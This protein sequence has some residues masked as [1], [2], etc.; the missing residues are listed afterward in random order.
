MVEPGLLL[1]GSPP[2]ARDYP[3]FRRRWTIGP[4]SNGARDALH[5]TAASPTGGERIDIEVSVE[6]APAVLWDAL[7]YYILVA[8][9]AVA[10]VPWA[11]LATGPSSP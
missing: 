6:T 10:L 3:K 11:E 8:V 5:A 7:T 4:W 1:S 2:H 9:F